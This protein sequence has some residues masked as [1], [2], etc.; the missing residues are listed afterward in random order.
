MPG[1]KKRALSPHRYPR[2]LNNPFYDG[3]GPYGYPGHH[4]AGGHPYYGGRYGAH[5]GYGPYYGGLSG[6][7]YPFYGP[8]LGH[9]A[10]AEK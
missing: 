4:F 2:S 3:Y 6:H 5:P 9:A 7:R 8:S 1:A 10:Y